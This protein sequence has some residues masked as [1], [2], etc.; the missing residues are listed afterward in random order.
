MQ[1]NLPPF[2]YPELRKEI[3]EILYKFFIY[4]YH[5]SF[6]NE[7]DQEFMESKIDDIL[8]LIRRQGGKYG[9]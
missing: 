2:E 1:S 9:V 4:E 3:Q 8:R 5:L 6:D 7:F